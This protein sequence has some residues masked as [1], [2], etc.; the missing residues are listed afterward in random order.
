MFLNEIKVRKN[1][2]CNA[3]GLREVIIKEDSW[4]LRTALYKVG[5]SRSFRKLCDLHSNHA[6]I[7]FGM[8][9]EI[10]TAFQ[11]T[12]YYTLLSRKFI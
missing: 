10:L 4:F 6:L 12:C 11:S 9:V 5:G 1:L 7:S 2:L 8:N 3:L